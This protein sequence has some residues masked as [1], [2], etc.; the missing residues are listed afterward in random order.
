MDALGSSEDISRQSEPGYE[1]VIAPGTFESDF[2]EGS[3]A[4]VPTPADV[5]VVE[6]RFPGTTTFMATE[7]LEYMI[8]PC[9]FKQTVVHGVRHDLESVYWTFLCTVYRRIQRDINRLRSCWDD[10]GELPELDN[11]LRAL[12]ASPDVA[13]LILARDLAFYSYCIRELLVCIDSQDSVLVRLLRLVWIL[14]QR[15]QPTVVQAFVDPD[16]D[17]SDR[18]LLERITGESLP[19]ESTVTPSAY[20]LALDHDKHV[21]LFEHIL[22]VI[23]ENAQRAAEATDAS[24]SCPS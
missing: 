19:R 17:E 5:V 2:G 10:S 23:A 21:K 15:C 1:A 7:L 20:A 11:E 18:S 13:H 14:L 3:D 4:A 16:L 6:F 22:Q 8:G 9:R 12:F 24:S